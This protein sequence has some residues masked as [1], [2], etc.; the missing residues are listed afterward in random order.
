MQEVSQLHVAAKL[1][2]KYEGKCWQQVIPN[3]EFPELLKLHPNKEYIRHIEKNMVEFTSKLED[4]VDVKCL[5]KDDAFY[6]ALTHTF[7]LGNTF[8]IAV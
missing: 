4:Y 6:N 8:Y 5:C 7:C 1:L 3:G 2:E